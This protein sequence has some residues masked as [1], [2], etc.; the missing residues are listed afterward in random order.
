MPLETLTLRAL[1][2]LDLRTKA[3]VEE[4]DRTLDIAA[5]VFINSKH[6]V[7]QINISHNGRDD[8]ANVQGSGRQ[9]A[10]LSQAGHIANLSCRILRAGCL[11][12]SRSHR[13]LDICG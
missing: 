10:R 13:L 9:R 7:K 4:P 1:G 2:R 11:S 6:G 5:T 3:L 12:S 8:K